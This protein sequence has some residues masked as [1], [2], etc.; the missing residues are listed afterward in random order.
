MRG[1]TLVLSALT[2]LPGCGGDGG[3]SSASAGDLAMP[4]YLVQSGKYSVSALQ[5]TDVDSCMQNLDVTTNFAT[6]GVTNNGVG[7]LG[8]GSN[9]VTGLPDPAM[10]NFGSGMFTD[11]LHATT[12]VEA[13]ANSNGC[14]FHLV[15]QCTVV[16]AGENLLDVQYRQV[17]TNHV[18]DC[19]I[20]ATDCSSAYHFTLSKPKQ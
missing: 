9:N 11:S 13:D 5:A 6:L 19:P 2:L 7:T 10:Y 12:K 20:V 4:L 15:R 8:L 17:Q 1:V 16:V 18:G 3:G 14:L